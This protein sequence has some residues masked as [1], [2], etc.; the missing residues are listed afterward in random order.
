[1][2]EPVTVKNNWN[3]EA[4]VFKPTFEEVDKKVPVITE[5]KEVGLLRGLNPTVEK[6]Q[7]REYKLDYVNYS[8]TVNKTM[9]DS[10]FIETIA[11]WLEKK[12]ANPEEMKNKKVVFAC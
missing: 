1:M 5:M 8:V 4:D 11:S 12:E 2:K 3:Q 9:S 7:R 6:V 10:F